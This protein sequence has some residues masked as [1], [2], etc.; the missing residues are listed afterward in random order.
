MEE[1]V[2]LLKIKKVGFARILPFLSPDQD[3]ASWIS[4]PSIN[5]DLFNQRSQSNVQIGYNLIII[6]HSKMIHGLTYIA[7]DA[8]KCLPYYNVMHS[9]TIC[10]DA[11]LAEL[12]S[13]KKTTNSLKNLSFPKSCVDKLLQST[14]D[15]SSSL[16]CSPNLGWCFVYNIPAD[17]ILCQLA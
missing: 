1:V 14:L 10:T 15:D 13:N 6:I 8:F 12:E 11:K 5:L 9:I 17:K 2:L 16:K 7:S 3:T 4:L